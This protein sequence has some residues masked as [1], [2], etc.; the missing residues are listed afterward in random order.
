MSYPPCERP[1]PSARLDPVDSF[2]EALWLMMSTIDT[3]P[4]Q[5]TVL[6]VLDDARWEQI[7]ELCDAAGLEWIVLGSSGVTCPREVSGAP[8]RWRRSPS[9]RCDARSPLRRRQTEPGAAESL[10]QLA[11]L[12]NARAGV[13][14]LL[15]IRLRDVVMVALETATRNTDEVSEV[16]QLVIRHIADQMAPLL[17][18]KPPARF[19]D[20]DGHGRHAARL[21]G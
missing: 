21:H 9:V 17:T 16:V 4:I 19:V 2:S 3:E 15:S 10:Y 6:L 20:Q 8:P 12:H 13:D 11:A 7:A 1:L 18:S 5:E 14:H